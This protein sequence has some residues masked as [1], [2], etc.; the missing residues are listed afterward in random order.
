MEIGIPDDRQR[1][2]TLQHDDF[3]IILCQK[4]QITIQSV[5]ML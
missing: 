2:L 1:L 3:N 5:S 4:L